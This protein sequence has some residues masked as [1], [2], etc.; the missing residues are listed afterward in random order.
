MTS[1]VQ[2]SFL[3]VTAAVLAAPLVLL[4]ATQAPPKPAPKTDTAAK[5]GKPS[6]IDVY[7]AQCLI[8]HGA[9]GDS[10]LPNMSFADGVWKHGTTTKELAE[11]VRNGVKGTLMLPFKDRLSDPEI[12]A[13]A[14]YVRTFDKKL[15]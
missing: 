7:K 5:A 4:A 6:G 11:V 8:C 13:V 9:A 14:A 10:P 2:R 12:L 3:A 1:V 15:K